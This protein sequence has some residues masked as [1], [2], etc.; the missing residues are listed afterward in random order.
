MDGSTDAGNVEDEVVA[1]LYCW[2]NDA[3]EVIRLCSRYFSVQ[4]PEKADADSLV[5][6]LGS[7]LRKL[8]IEIVFVWDIPS[9]YIFGYF[10]YFIQGK[11]FLDISAYFRIHLRILPHSDTL[12]ISN[13]Y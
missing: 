9:L 13:H 12:D 4:V 2:K 6:C 5:R 11:W 8:D 10:V 7:A 3:T 1:L